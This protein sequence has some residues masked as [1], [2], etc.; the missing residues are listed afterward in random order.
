ME[1][2]HNN[3]NNNTETPKVLSLSSLRTWFGEK[4]SELPSL[5]AWSTVKEKFEELGEH[6]DAKLDYFTGQ[7]PN[8]TSS[9]PTEEIPE[10]QLC[11]LP[12]E[13]L[14][15]IFG[16]LGSVHP[17][18]LLNCFYVSK[19]W[20]QIASDRYLW[21]S[22]YTY[23]LRRW[24]ILIVEENF[25]NAPPMEDDWGAKAVKLLDFFDSQTS[26]RRRRILTSKTA[27]GKIFLNYRWNSKLYKD[28]IDEYFKEMQFVPRGVPNLPQHTKKLNLPFGRK[29]YKIPMFGEGLD[30]SAKKLLYEI[31]WS[32]ESPFRFTDL[33]PGVAGIGSGVGVSINNVSLHLAAIYV[34]DRIERSLG[35]FFKSANGFIF[36]MDASPDV[37]K[38]KKEMDLVLEGY[39]RPDTP[40][41]ILVCGN[42]GHMEMAL[43][44]ENS[45]V[46][47]RR[48][49]VVGMLSHD[50][51]C[52]F[53]GLDWLSKNLP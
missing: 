3:S 19:R 21:Q 37:S 29:V 48:W 24:S 7:V 13:L 41:L 49:C 47:K 50:L 44:L 10:S 6:L 4:T 14:F 18:D 30:N 51:R 22:L 8:R 36:V 1:P 16:F 31:M 17:P 27:I 2:N 38:A 20:H 46:G 42:E 23:Y 39:G 5:P 32:P 26:N 12:K 28:K 34:P 33:Y 9:E 43:E 53:K 25:E 52:V 15:V 45:G 35:D 11:F 40:V